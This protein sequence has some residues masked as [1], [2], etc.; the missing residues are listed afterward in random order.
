MSKKSRAESSRSGRLIGPIFRD[1][2]SPKYSTCGSA[3]LESLDWSNWWQ[4]SGY[5]HVRRSTQGDGETWHRVYPKRIAGRQVKRVAVTN[6][7]PVWLHDK[8]PTSGDVNR[9]E[10]ASP[11]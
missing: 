5:I 6:G 4:D 10:A 11:Q 2:T 8:T 9:R 1:A 3:S 7:K